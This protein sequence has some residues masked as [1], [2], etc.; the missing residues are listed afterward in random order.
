MANLHTDTDRILYAGS[1]FLFVAS[2]AFI[3]RYI[4]LLHTLMQ[5]YPFHDQ[6]RKY[7]LIDEVDSATIFICVFTTIA[8]IMDLFRT[9]TLSCPSKLLGNQPN[10]EYHAFVKHSSWPYKINI[11]AY[12]TL[13]LIFFWPEN[14]DPEPYLALPGVLV[15]RFFSAVFYDIRSY[16]Y[17]IR[18]QEKQ[19]N[20]CL[21]SA[22][23][24]LLSFIVSLVANICFTASNYDFTPRHANQTT[25]NWLNATFVLYI[26]SA[27]LIGIET[28]INL[29]TTSRPS[30]PSR[31]ASDESRQPL[32]MS[33]SS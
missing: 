15:A 10:E 22:P 24:S 32:A 13:T 23:I 6:L 1:H 9:H 26:A 27:V 28:L 3:A 2:N 5:E 20:K 11:L 7:E 30:R 31:P 25:S 18:K 29:F 21:Q 16:T 12:I 14:N 8:L 4:S 33:A 19:N 17:A